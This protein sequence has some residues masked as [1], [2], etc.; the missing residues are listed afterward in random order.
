MEQFLAVAI[1]HFV[2]L[3]IPG[4]DFF[5]IA[6]V[7]LAGGWRN[8]TGAC[9]G[10][11]LA[12]GAFIAAA[13]SGIAL[14]TRPP[15]L[16]AIQA[17]GGG[18]LVFMGI[19]FLRSPARIDLEHGPSAARGT[20]LRNLGLGLASGLLNPKNALFY[21]SLAAAVPGEPPLTLALYGAW[22]FGIVLAWDVLSPSC[23]APGG[24]SGGCGA[25][26]PGSAGAR[27]SSCSSSGRGCSSGRRCGR[28]RSAG[29]ACGRVALA[30][31]ALV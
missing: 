15:L 24:H 3:L 1:A 17:V 22:M 11:A 4:V 26:C 2:S 9:L 30:M 12:N 6:R 31:R 13:F 7:A 5:L 23:S 21:V 16:D 28:S 27:A 8:A 10:I 19:A 25:R 14:I 18:F 29:D 20:W